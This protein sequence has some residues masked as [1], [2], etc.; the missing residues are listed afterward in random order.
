MQQ[1][2]EEGGKNDIEELVDNSELLSHYLVIMT[3]EKNEKNEY[4][5]VCVKCDF[6]CFY[7]S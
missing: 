4:N 5:Y 7:N 1:F 6:K 2:F 3:T